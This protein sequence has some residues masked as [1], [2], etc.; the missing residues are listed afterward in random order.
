M[1]PRYCTDRVKLALA[2][3]PV[4]VISGPRQCGKTTLVKNLQL[5]NW[6]Y[7]SLDDPTQLAEAK[8][9]PT[10]FVRQFTARHIVIDEVQRVP[11]L[12]LPIKQLVDEDRR[13][14]RFILTGS[15]DAKLIPNLSDAL[16]GRMESIPLLPLAQ[17]EIR[18]SAGGFLKD[19]L[20]GNIPKQSEIRIRQRLIESAVSGGFP[21]PLSPDNASRQVAWFQ[22]YVQTIVQRDLL[23]FGRLEHPQAMA[24]L[25]QAMVNQVGQLTNILTLSEQASLPRQTVARYMALLEQIFIFE[26][27]PAWHR[28]HT[29]R[30]TK[31]PK[32]HCVDSG[33]VCALQN[34]TRAVLMENSMRLGAVVESYVYCELRRL[35]SWH[36]GPVYFYHYRDKDK[37]EVD[38]VLETA[39]GKVIG[40]EI[41]SGATVKREHFQ[42]L[43][44]LKRA[45]G[46]D[47]LTGII[48]YDGDHTT[49]HG[50]QMVSIPLSSIW[51]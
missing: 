21:E 8:A 33:L 31:T 47:F 4:V 34:S 28:N 13:P 32:L 26:Q 1:Y 42:G 2:D 44:R 17:C 20:A 27:L 51:A 5:E 50:K 29:K 3:T 15:A 36:D 49:Q 9:D 6:H 14:G 43:E 45:A 10:G 22:Q 48:L 18:E 11:E 7:V 16:V 35:A 12:F 24:R 38:V 37:V 25:I 19:I 23:D 39:Q 46:D 30:L 40:I 41:K